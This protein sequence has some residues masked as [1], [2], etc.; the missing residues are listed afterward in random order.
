MLAEAPG[1]FASV[2][3]HPAT[4][5]ALADAYRELRTAPDPALDAVADCS[6]RASDV[7]RI[8]RLVH[9]RLS[10]NWYDEEDLLTVAADII[11]SAEG[12]LPQPVMIH[13]LPKFTSGEIALVRAPA[14][15]AQ[16]LVNVGI[17]GDAEADEATAAAYRAPA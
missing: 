11:A 8:F 3:E 9:E 4:E 15:N 17:T 6:T 13:L 2:A 12:K 7:V 14:D 5:R 1:V 10:S 16:L